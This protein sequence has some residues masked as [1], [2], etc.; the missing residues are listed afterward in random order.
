MTVAD[1]DYEIERRIVIGFIVST[2]YV[3]Q[4]RDLYEPKLIE[5][6][7]ANRLIN[8]CV[9]Y[10][11][12]Y[13]E[14]PFRDIESIYIQKLHNGD[15]PNDI[16]EEVEEDILPE[17]NK[18]YEQEKFNYQYLL[19][20][21]KQLFHERQLL[22]FSEEVKGLVQAG[23]LTEAEKTASSY[24]PPLAQSSN[25]LD[26]SDPNTVDEKVESL[27]HDE[28]ERVVHY[29]GALGSMWNDQ[30]VRDGLVGLMA[31]EKRGKTWWLLDI[32][33]RGAKQGS[34][35]AFFQAGDMSE[36]Q[37]LRRICVRLTGRPTSEKQAGK[38]FQPVKDCLHNQMHN[39][40]REDRESLFG[41][42]PT[43]EGWN[44]NQVR[45]DVDMDMLI[46]RYRDNPDYIP[47]FSHVCPYKEGNGAVWVREVEKKPLTSTEAKEA[48]HKFLKTNKFKLSTHVNGTLTIK[49]IK[50][51]LETWER[52]EGFVPDLIVVDYADLLSPDDG[53]LDFR[54]QQDRIWQG[55]RSL[56]QERHCL[57]VTATQADAKSYERDRLALSNFS[58]DKRKY[59]H[60]T[61][62]YGL[63]Q[64]RDGREKKIGLMRINELV[65]R[66]GEFSN[67]NEAKALQNLQ[68]GKPF[69]GSYF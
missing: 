31:P 67:L 11:D 59:A 24:A 62:M 33:I 27:F 1:K 29:P 16:A 25:V 15:L 44:K 58:E 41:V 26:F 43:K 60:V 20:Q 30:L 65:V 13:G 68:V 10:F 53:R 5:S 64:D 21:T 54:H 49:E 36:K 57:V 28:L 7:L 42:F 48:V 17:L 45:Y 18:K 66:E 38:M 8:W 2:E 69:T 55:L 47:C 22:N 6:K 9:E 40:D 4:V 50:S 46:Q 14:V 37:Q 35:V 51:L 12:K 3:R 63:N 39:C 19:D 34:K 52:Q 61:A 56:S 32:A 23:E